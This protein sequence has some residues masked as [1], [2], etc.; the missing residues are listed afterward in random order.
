MGRL[1]RQGPEVPLHVVAAQTRV[2]QALLRADEVLELHRVLDEENGR[3][4]AHQV[5]VA[6]L[7]VELQRE[8]ARVALGVRA[9]LFGRDRGEPGQHLGAL[10]RLQEVRLG[11]R[12]DVGGDDELSERSAALGVHDPF[13]HTFPVELR[14]LLQEVVVLQQDPAAGALGQ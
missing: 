14:H 10:A 5:V 2:R 7:G 6:Q 12:A 4:V 9:T 3:V 11:V 13:G 1:R 8:P